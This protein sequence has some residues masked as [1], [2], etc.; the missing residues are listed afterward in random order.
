MKYEIFIY[1]E[2]KTAPFYKKAIAEYEKRLSRYCKI[3]CRFIKKEKVWKKI[4]VPATDNYVLL[5]GKASVSSEEFSDRMKIWEISGKGQID[6]FIPGTELSTLG[7]GEEGRERRKKEEGESD[8]SWNVLNLSAFSMT[9]AL[10]GLILYE[11]IYR[12]YRILNHHP[13]HK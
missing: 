6:F 5:P 1:E 12:G 11:Q 8:S 9:S 2:M 10:S 3:S 13:Y 4:F 7:E